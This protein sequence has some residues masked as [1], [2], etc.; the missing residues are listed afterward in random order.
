M[1]INIR[2]HTSYNKTNAAA[3]RPLQYIVIHYTAGSTS[4]SGA[5]V[6]TADFWA[7]GPYEGSA[8]FVVDDELIVQYNPDLKNRLCWHC[9]DGK[10]YY[11]KGGSFYGKCSNYNSIGIE[12]CS[13]NLNYSPN[14]PANS[15]KW[16]FTSAAVDRAVELTKYLMQTYGID[17]D[18]VIRHYDVSGKL[19]PGIIGWNEDSKDVSKWKAFKARLSGTS[20]TTATTKTENSSTNSTANKTLYRVQI[21]AFSE[22][23]NADTQLFNVKAKGFK[24]AFVTKVDTWYKVQVGAFENKT[25]AE[26]QLEK[27]KQAGFKDCFIATNGIVKKS[28]TEIAKEVIAGKWGAGAERKTALEKAGYDYNA[29][30]SKVNELMR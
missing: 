1:S 19:C 17:A 25:N 18:H 15:P 8:D 14:D 4:R 28:V 9:G 24:D 12:I 21:G 13:T 27:V 16:S 5:A 20:S 7:T 30:Q 23:S 22:K 3:N 10:N 29:V 2:K 6:N 26:K 11:S